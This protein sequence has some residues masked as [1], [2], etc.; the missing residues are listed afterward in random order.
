MPAMDTPSFTAADLAQRFALQLHGDGSARVHGVA[1][2]AKAGPGQLAFLA[3][4]RY[5]G[6]LAGSK[7]AVVVLRAEDADAAPG[8]GPTTTC[9]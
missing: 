3:N 8:T 9:W 4:P 6:Q 1:T 5:R 2:L 7:A